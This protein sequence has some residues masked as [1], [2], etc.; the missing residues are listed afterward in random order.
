MHFEKVVDV[1]NLII[2]MC[3]SLN[4]YTK[5]FCKVSGFMYRHNFNSVSE[6]LFG[7]NY[8]TSLCF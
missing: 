8:N 4:S 2:R 7:A 1:F 3:D 6:G 5:L